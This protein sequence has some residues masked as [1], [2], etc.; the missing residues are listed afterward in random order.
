MKDRVRTEVSCLI[1]EFYWISQFYHS[2]AEK[3]SISYL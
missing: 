2:R 3:V 1:T